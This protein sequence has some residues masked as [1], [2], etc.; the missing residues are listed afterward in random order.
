MV[1]CLSCLRIV[2][3][4]Q[5]HNNTN[6]GQK[7]FFHLFFTF[8]V[9]IC[10]HNGYPFRH[11]EGKQLKERKNEVVRLRLSQQLKREVE[12]FSRARGISVSNLFRIAVR[13]YLDE[14][15]RAK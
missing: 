7:P 11:M 6:L 10:G 4:K 3:T 2:T 14:A 13:C 12:V 9:A 1:S 8:S 5:P 15:K